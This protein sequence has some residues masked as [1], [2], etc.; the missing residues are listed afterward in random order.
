MSFDKNSPE[1]KARDRRSAEIVHKGH[2]CKQLVFQHLIRFPEFKD[3]PV[4][5]LDRCRTL[6]V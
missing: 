1:E 4:G 3:I 2:M 6:C 5:K